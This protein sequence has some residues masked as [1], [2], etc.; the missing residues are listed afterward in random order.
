MKT[1]ILTIIKNEHRYLDEWIRYH[2][3]LGFDTLFIL[4]DRG[5]ESHK[6]I[7]DKY[8]NVIL[9]SASE[10]T[11][12]KQARIFNEVYNNVIKQEYDW[13]LLLDTDEFVTC[14]IPFNIILEKHKNDPYIWLQWHNYGASGIINKN[15]YRKPIWETY[16]KR[17]GN[18]N[19][20]EVFEKTGKMMYNC[21]KHDDTLY[22]HRFPN[23]PKQEDIYIRHYIT[24]SWSEWKWKI[25][26]R[27]MHNPRH[28]KLE[29]FFIY[30][31]E[32][33]D[34]ILNK[35]ISTNET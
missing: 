29:N 22:I 18:M 20:D 32:M 4:E 33:K 5:S 15:V 19:V 11:N 21:K 1:V 14:D 27:G 3:E 13:C 17:C 24:K 8:P 26:E 2:C 9:R 16:T 6:H 7:T 23:A 10:F 30:N 12:T 31:P 25:E 35:N 28:R 34:T